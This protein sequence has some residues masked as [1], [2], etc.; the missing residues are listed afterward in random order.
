MIEEIFE[1]TKVG[2]KGE[3]PTRHYFY[4]YLHFN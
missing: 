4:S 1:K 2:E 3:I